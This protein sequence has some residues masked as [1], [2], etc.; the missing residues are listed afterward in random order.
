MSVVTTI[1]ATIMVVDTITVG[2]MITIGTTTVSETLSLDGPIARTR[3]VGSDS[4]PAKSPAPKI[5][6]TA[7]RNHCA[8]IMRRG[9]L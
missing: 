1:A 3:C 9:N 6:D 8:R 7:C 5:S 4:T 2:T